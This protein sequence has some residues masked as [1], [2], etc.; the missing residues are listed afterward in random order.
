MAHKS[1][2]GLGFSGQR[3]GSW[4]AGSSCL[5]QTGWDKHVGNMNPDPA[6]YAP[7]F[8]NF[9]ACQP[10]HPLLFSNENCNNKNDMFNT[11]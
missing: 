2:E 11:L 10:W 9:F 3:F 5:W 1:E 4:R 8:C 6:L 7:Q